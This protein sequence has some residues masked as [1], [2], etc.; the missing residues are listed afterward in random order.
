VPPTQGID[1]GSRIAVLRVCHPIM[2]GGINQPRTMSAVDPP[3]RRRSLPP[4]DRKMAG[5]FACHDE[6]CFMAHPAT[7][8][9]TIQMMMFIG[10]ALGYDGCYSKYAE[11]HHGQGKDNALSSKIF[12][13]RNAAPLQ[14]RT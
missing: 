3:G 12:L 7:T 13:T 2:P 6:M 5:W 9:T 4:P 10:Q 8:Q 1:T 11:R 14:P